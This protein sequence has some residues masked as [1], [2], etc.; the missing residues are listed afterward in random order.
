MKKIIKLIAALAAVVGLGF[1]VR[2]FTKKS[3]DQ[4]AEFEQP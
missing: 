3:D 2:K 4:S 1:L